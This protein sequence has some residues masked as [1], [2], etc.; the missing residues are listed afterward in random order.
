M[1]HNT[2]KGSVQRPFDKQKFEDSWERI[3]GKHPQQKD[4]NASTEENETDKERNN[5]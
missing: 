5:E 1:S 3:F 4:E 2:V